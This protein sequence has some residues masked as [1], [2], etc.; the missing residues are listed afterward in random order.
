M[1]FIPFKQVDVFTSTP[2]FE[3]PVA[4]VLDAQALDTEAMQR[5]ANWANLSE[6]TFVLAPT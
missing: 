2:Y 3:N 6:T 1:P 5:I 4:V